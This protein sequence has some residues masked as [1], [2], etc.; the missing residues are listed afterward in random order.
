M[1]TEK[2]AAKTATKTAAES[3]EVARKSALDDIV[4][5]ILSGDKFT[6]TELRDLESFDA[7]VALAQREFG[8]VDTADQVLGDGFAVLDKATK[9]RLVGVPCLF[10]SWAFRPGDF[11]RPFVSVRVIARGNTGGVSKYILNDGST[12]IAEQLASYTQRTGKS[13]GLVIAKGLR[14]SEYEYED[15]RGNLIPATT[16]YIDTS[17]GV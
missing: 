15:E 6:E 13:G 9:A 11:G 12:G 5:E 2:T 14:A 1:A 7:A 8:A 16:Y 10:L 17:A 3:Q 4:P